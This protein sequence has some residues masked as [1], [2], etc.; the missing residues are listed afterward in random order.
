MSGLGQMSP[1]QQQAL[2]QALSGAIGQ[3]GGSGS[4]SQYG[5]DITQGLGS[6]GAFNPT[7]L[8][9]LNA[10]PWL[11]QLQGLG[12]GYTNAGGGNTA[13][14]EQSGMSNLTSALQPALNT[15]ASN[16]V[17]S[18]FQPSTTTPNAQATAAGYNPLQPQYLSTPPTLNATTMQGQTL[19]PQLMGSLGSGATQQ[20]LQ[21]SVAPQY[22][23]QDQQMMQM[24]ATAGVAPSSTAGQTAFSNL[25]QGQL[26][27][28][29]PAMASAI[30]N[31][32]ANQLNAGQYNAN[33]L[34]SS[35]QFNANAQNT[36]SGQNLNNL[37]QQQLYNANAYNGAGT[38]YFNAETGAYNNNANAFNALNQQ[39]L[40][41]SQSLANTQAAGGN[42]FANTQQTQYPVY[43]NSGTAAFGQS[44]GQYGSGGGSQQT[45]AAINPGSSGGYYPNVA[46]GNTESA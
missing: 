44:V 29:S 25:A 1:Q 27:G 5:Q 4:Y 7:E 9:A 18:Q 14:F 19:S 37:L 3:M 15:E 13:G 39:G 46:G 38:N 42:Q 12:G 20:A 35:G 45:P 26:A 6:S 8:S 32:Q 41:G 16:G 2:Q 23:Q 34:N 24:L 17:M 33:S 36:A 10:S 43:G 31:S 21:N 28:I 11:A 40:G 22:G 30:Q